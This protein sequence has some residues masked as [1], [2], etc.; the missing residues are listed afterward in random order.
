MACGEMTLAEFTGFLAGV[1]QQTS[2]VLRAGAVQY[3]FMDWRHISEIA[4]GG[5]GQR[6]GALEPVRLEQGLR[7]HGLASTARSTN[8]S[9]CSSSPARPTKTT[10]SSGAL[11]ATAPMSGTCRAARPP[12]RPSLQLHATPK[13]VALIAEAIRDASSRNDIVLDAFS[14]SGTTIIAAAKTGRRARVHRARPALCRCQRA[15]L[16]GLVGSGS[17]ACHDRPHLRTDP[18]AARWRAR[19]RGDRA[20]DAGLHDA[21]R[22]SRTTRA[23]GAEGLGAPAPARCAV[24]GGGP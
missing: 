6:P 18:G 10:C 7:R 23:G 16:A 4:G 17:G 20:G 21:V 15:A 22:A 11:A 8:S 24:I 13:P 19:D 5:P 12:C 3:A 2:A 1:L 14:G 9:S